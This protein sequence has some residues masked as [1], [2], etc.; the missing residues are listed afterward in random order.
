MNQVLPLR[1]LPTQ[2]QLF[3][4]ARTPAPEVTLRAPKIRR[5]SSRRQSLRAQGCK[6]SG[7]VGLGPPSHLCKIAARSVRYRRVLGQGSGL[8]V[9]LQCS[10]RSCESPSGSRPQRRQASG[11]FLA[12]PWARIS[13]TQA[14]SREGPCSQLHLPTRRRGA[15]A[16]LEIL[17]SPCVTY[18]PHCQCMSPKALYSPRH[19][20]RGSETSCFPTAE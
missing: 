15:A 11:R 3:T 10:S 8:R 6:G 5:T 20:G 7:A 9:S 13:I 12:C 4:P 17:A 14:W 2:K 19:V 16:V 1:F 18:S